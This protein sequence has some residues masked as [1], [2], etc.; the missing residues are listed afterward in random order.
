MRRKQKRDGCVELR[1][2]FLAMSTD[3]IAGHSLDGSNPQD[4]IYLLDND[5]NAKEWQ[6]TIAAL[7]SLKPLV[8]QATWLIPLALKISVAI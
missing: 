4:T 3:T 2:N 6:T 7:A 8:K 5:D 1:V